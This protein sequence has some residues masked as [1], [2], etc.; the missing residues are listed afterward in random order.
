M[1]IIGS[2]TQNENAGSG[3]VQIQID[4]LQSAID[5]INADI[6]TLTQTLTTLQTSVNAQIDSETQTLLNTLNSQMSDLRTSLESAVSTNQ[7]TAVIGNIQQLAVTVSATIN[8]LTAGSINATTGITTANLTSASSDIGNAQAA[9][10]STGSLDATVATLGTVSASV[11]NVVTFIIENL[12]TTNFSATNGAVTNF[13]TSLIKADTITGKQWHTPV[14][15]PDNTEL[16]R[17]RIP[18]Y[19]GIITFI[20]EDGE[21]NVTIIN[22]AFISY[23]QNVQYLYRIDSKT[24]YID[25]Y[26]SNIDD[27]IN[28]QV[29]YL[30]EGEHGT[31]TSEIVDKTGIQQ[32]IET[33]KGIISISS[34]EL[35]VELIFVQSLPEVGRENVIYLIETEGAFIWNE[36]EDKY[37]C[38]AGT[39]YQR[40]VLTDSVTVDEVEQTTVEGAIGALATLANS[41]KSLKQDKALTNPVTANGITATTVEGAIDALNAENKIVDGTLEVEEETYLDSDVVAEKNVTVKGDLIVNGTTYT[42]EEES[43][44]TKADYVVLR[45]NNPSGLGANEKSGIVIHNYSGNK[46]ASLGVDKDGIFRIS[47]NVSE[48]TTTYTNVS[49]FNGSYYSGLTQDTAQVISSGAVVAQDEDELS[50]CVYFNGVYYHRSDKWFA[51]SLVSNALTVGSEV[52]DET[53]LAALELLTK[54]ELF[55]YRTL[56]VLAVQDS[57]NQ[58]VMTRAEASDIPDGSLLKWDSV[59]SKAVAIDNQPSAGKLL[60]YGTDTQTVYSDK[61]CVIASSDGNTYTQTPY[62]DNFSDITSEE[63]ISGISSAEIE[64]GFTNI[65]AVKD[66]KSLYMDSASE[67]F[68]LYCLDNGDYYEVLRLDSNNDYVLA[69]EPTVS[70]MMPLVGYSVMRAYRCFKTVTTNQYQWRTAFTDPQEIFDIIHPVGE[71]YVQYPQQDPP[72]TIYNKSG[73]TSTWTVIDYN[74]AFFRAQGGNANAFSEKGSV[75]S[76]QSDATAVKGLSVSASHNFKLRQGNDD[77][78]AE[79]TTSGMS[80]NS[81]GTF[82]ARRSDGLN[83]KYP[84][85]LDCSGNVTRIAI[86]T[87]YRSGAGEGSNLGVNYKIDVTHTHNIY[88]RGGISASISS[89]DIETRPKNYTVRIWKRTA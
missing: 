31:V 76:T 15:L 50:D 48:A 63:E 32:N 60:G 82:N 33:L 40:K 56:S 34:K 69:D 61:F 77:S 11:L 23:N 37:Y 35:N 84:A 14:S 51:V 64:T 58:P 53:T 54:Y 70:S 36:Q 85:D 13:E 52:T 46:S 72:A 20:S 17:V 22:N 18:A 73:I 66:L 21:V 67:D 78:S 83:T 41:N 8:A 57:T 89:T 42:T 4:S 5:E 27:T 44:N 62:V 79:N 1:I 81:E 75:L 3:Q 49:Q 68:R 59:N 24:D 71:V 26:L 9:S 74:G 2:N 55:Y 38:F 10:L 29:I 28:Y 87:S 25:L 43:L 30:G 7:I 65:V 19:D 6:D 45:E 12:T 16:L 86:G 39:V 47:D 80:G 88:L